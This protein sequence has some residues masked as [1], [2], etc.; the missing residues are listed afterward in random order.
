MAQVYGIVEQHDGFIDVHTAPEQGTTFM[1]YFPLL[2][3][4]PAELTDADVLTLPEGAGELILVV[5]DNHEARE[6]LVDSLKML[7]YRVRDS[8]EWKRGTDNLVR[9][10]RPGFERCYYAGNGWNCLYSMP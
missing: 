10:H 3:S 5:E 1:L 7:N 6:A 2:S 8:P 4:Q 9:G